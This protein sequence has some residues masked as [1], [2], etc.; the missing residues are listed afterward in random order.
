MLAGTHV[1]HHQLG[2][3]R[4]APSIPALMQVTA[5]AGL[6]GRVYQMNQGGAGHRASAEV[7]GTRHELA[8]TRTSLAEDRAFLASERSLLAWYRTAFGACACQSSR[9]RLCRGEAGSG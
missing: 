6:G 4:L 5:G 9:R 1:V 8:Q 7:S 3:L 2:R